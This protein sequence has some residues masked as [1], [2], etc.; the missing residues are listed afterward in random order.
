MDQSKLTLLK[1]LGTEAVEAFEVALVAEYAELRTQELSVDGVTELTALS[2]AITTVRAELADRR[3]KAAEAEV[4]PAPSAEELASAAAAADAAI[5]VPAEVPT[6]EFKTK[7]AEEED[8]KDGGKDDA[9]EDVNGKKKVAAA[10]A[11]TV[12]LSTTGLE[13]DLEDV[14]P[15]ASSITAGADIPGHSAGSSFTDFHAVAEAFIARRRSLKGADR[16]GDGDDVI[17]ASVAGNYPADRVLDATNWQ[18]NMEKIKAVASPE[19]VTASGGLCAPL[20]PYYGIQVIS[21][22][23]RPVRDALPKFSADRGG[24]RFLPPPRLSDLTGAI[25]VTTAEQDAGTY[26]EG[27]GDTPFKPCLHVTC[28]EEQTVEIEA[29]HRCLT[30]GN[31][32]ARTYPEQ[33]EAWLALAIAAHAR[34]AETLLLDAID[35]ASTHTTGAASYSAVRTLLPQVDQA[36]AAYRSRN[37]TAPG[38]ALRVMLPDWT[39]ELIRADLA[40]GFRGGDLEPLF[41]SDGQ[42]ADWFTVR[43]VNVTFY[44]DSATGANQVFGS[45]GAS[46]LT[47]FP[48]TVVWYLY[49]E[50]S[51]VFLDGGT[52]DL[53]L[54]R[55]ST[56]NK[57][58]DYQIFAETFEAVAFYGVES[59][60]VTST[61]CPNGTYAPAASGSAPC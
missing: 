58:N 9:E 15:V 17:V 39:K 24:V 28:G 55:D 25:G 45:Q 6:E 59:I 13:S 61:V 36:I 46:A 8:A 11:E 12:E 5:E 32:A 2:T 35:T 38:L 53:G 7:A 43:G 30:F 16:A 42:I 51:F 26:G 40:R 33:V 57:T 29:I 44:I 20:E 52:L 49:V 31:F 50:G 1:D 23:N 21:A 34:R 3:T 27:E 14:K 18:S 37:R 47:A 4:A 10:A 54:V 22:A 48:S 56:L 60:K 41:V 19:A